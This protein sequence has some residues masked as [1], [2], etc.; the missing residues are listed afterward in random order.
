MVIYLLYLRVG[1]R[2]HNLWELH[3]KLS[4]MFIYNFT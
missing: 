1:L 3:P 4:V 2:N